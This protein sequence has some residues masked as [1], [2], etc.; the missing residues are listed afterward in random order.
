M[1]QKSEEKKKQKQKNRPML[2]FCTRERDQRNQV[3]SLFSTLQS[4]KTKKLNGAKQ[5]K[6]K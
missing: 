6:K 1:R 3:K 4:Q 2:K 5:S